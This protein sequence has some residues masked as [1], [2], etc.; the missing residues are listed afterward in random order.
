MADRKI[1]QM[2]WVVAKLDIHPLDSDVS[3]TSAIKGI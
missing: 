3:M 1:S 2:Q